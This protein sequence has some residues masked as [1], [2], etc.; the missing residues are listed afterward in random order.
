MLSESPSRLVTSGRSFF[1]SLATGNLHRMC[2]GCLGT[3]GLAVL[4]FGGC[5]HGGEG[6]VEAGRAASAPRL[7]LSLA[8]P[9]EDHACRHVQTAHGPG[10][11]AVHLD[12]LPP[13]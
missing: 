11:P 2:S 9:H 3:T 1:L 10:D 8:D 5:L 6:E 4:A 7:S 12:C 13:P